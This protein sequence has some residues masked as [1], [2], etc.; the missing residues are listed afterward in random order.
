M[1]KTGETFEALKS[2]EGCYETWFSELF[3]EQISWDVIDAPY[4]DEL[5]AP[6]K[7]ERLLITGS[8][9]SIYERREWSVSCSQWLAKIWE[10]GVPILGICY[11]HQL[12]ADALGGEVSASTKGREM[13]AIDVLQCGEDLLFSGLDRQ[14]SVWQ[15][16]IDEVSRA[17]EVAEIIATNDHCPIQAM[18]IGDHCRTVQW[19]PEM[20][21][22]IMSHYV[23]AR[24]EAIESQWGKG[25]A[26][27]LLQSLPEEVLS[28]SMIAQNFM[29]HWLEL[30]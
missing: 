10:R 13:G 20:N 18:A 4:G 17:P 14:F 7:I 28:G 25:S 5:P 8:P 12:M 16:H 30:T 11:G 29:S 15:T 2:Y 6:E 27:E 9:V 26:I 23:E 3:G 1:L 22:A 24:R 21:K 19:H